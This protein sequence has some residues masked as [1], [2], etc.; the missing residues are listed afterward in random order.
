MSQNADL[1][2]YQKLIDDAT[3]LLY[4]SSESPRIDA[5]VLLQHAIEKPLAWLIAYGDTNATNEHLIEFYR[6]VELR[7]QGQPIAYITGHKEF[8]SLDL[9]VNK[10]VLIPRPDTEILVEQALERLTPKATQQILDLGTGSGAIA[11]SLAK[12]RP[13]AS[14]LATDSQTSALEVAKL[15]AESHHLTNVAFICS[16]WFTELVADQQFDLIASNPPYIDATDQH[17]AQGDLRFEPNSALVGSEDGLG[18]IR[19][20]IEAAPNYLKNGGH[21]L[22]EHGYDQAESV[23]A[24]LVTAGFNNITNYRDLNNL[25]RCTAANFTH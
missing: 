24:L 21:L 8:W 22:I 25:P 14:V 4:E 10:A 17:L 20:I 16:D 18:D 12:E 15:N 19:V 1:R 23:K 7:Q 13:Q 2:T 11:L 5:E 3:T 9:I 6:L